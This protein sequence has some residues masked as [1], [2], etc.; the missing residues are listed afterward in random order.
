MRFVRSRPARHAVLAIGSA[1]IALAAACG[2][3][4]DGDGGTTGPATGVI[5]GR[6][7]TGTESVAGATVTL[8]G[9]ASRTATTNVTGNFTFAALAPG[10]YSV[11]VALPAAF[12]LVTGQT[13]AR[14]ATVTA[15]QTA[16]VNWTAQRVTGGTVVEVRLAGTSFSP[17]TVNIAAGTTVRWIVENGSHTV[18][19]DTPAQSGVWNDSGI[20]NAGQTF[21]HTF[22]VA[23]Q[24]YAYHCTPHQSLGMVGT[25][26]VA[27]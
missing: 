17:G 18:T 4:D 24:E 10:D 22:T 3:G 16:T 20:M 25:V 27:P 12:Q 15:G 19:P 21:E 8:T 14:S 9:A 1:A 11:T 2:G 7:A 26:R 13:A 23:G 5:T 6:V